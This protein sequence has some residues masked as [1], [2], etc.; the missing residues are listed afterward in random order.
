MRV[1][2]FDGFPQLDEDVIPLD[3]STKKNNQNKNKS[4][5]ARPPVSHYTVLLSCHFVVLHSINAPVRL[6]WLG[7]PKERPV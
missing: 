1:H 7:H 4:V 3:T 5:K 2:P 6:D